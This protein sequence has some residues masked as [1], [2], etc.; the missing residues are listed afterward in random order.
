VHKRAI[1]DGPNLAIAEKSGRRH[2][3]DDFVQR[4]DVVI[5]HAVHAF[6]AAQA[7]DNTAPSGSFGPSSSFSLIS[8]CFNSACAL[9]PSRT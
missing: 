6:A 3:A 8:N 9:S 5:A 1:A 7:T 4:V 2:R